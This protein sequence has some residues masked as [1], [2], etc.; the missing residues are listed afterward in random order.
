ML[1]GSSMLE[2]GVGMAMFYL[3]MAIVVSSINEVIA[4]AIRLRWTN[5]RDGIGQLLADPNAKAIG[6]QVLD[7]PLVK[8]LEKRGR[9]SYISSRT[10]SAAFVDVIGNGKRTIDEIRT[11]VTANEA[12]PED[13]RRQLVILLNDA[14]GDV[15]QFRVAIAAWFDDSMDRVAGW[16]RRK[17]QVVTFL[18]ALG[19]VIFLNADTLRLANGML[20]NP[21]AREAF[22]AQASTLVVPTSSQ[23]AEAYIAD[24][25][26]A[27]Q[28]LGI[29]LG[30]PD[31]DVGDPGK[32]VGYIA[33]PANWFGHVPGWLVTVFAMLMGAPFWFDVIRKVANVS[34]AGDP[35]PKNTAPTS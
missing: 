33:T 35:P 29:E 19:I 21:A 7:H 30:W 23:P 15:D 9:P 32:I 10:F 12:I 3:L 2:V 31:I 13:L 17:M 26:R 1:F 34:S 14:G 5:L 6:A 11:Q 18:V 25:Q 20:Q 16:Y 4:R 8:S 24:V 22:V 28:P 27:I